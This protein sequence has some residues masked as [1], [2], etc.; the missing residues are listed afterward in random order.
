MTDTARKTRQLDFP[1]VAEAAQRALRVLAP[2][3]RGAR[4]EKGPSNEATDEAL[5]T[6]LEML[7][8]SADEHGFGSSDLIDIA[9]L[10]SIWWRTWPEHADA[11]VHFLETWPPTEKAVCV[12]EL[13]GLGTVSGMIRL[14][15]TL[16]V[17]GAGRSSGCG[18]TCRPPFGALIPLLCAAHRV[19]SAIKLRP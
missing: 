7:S 6:E 5:W 4:A 8:S 2:D 11:M 1:A 14:L 17:S 12:D 19:T 9:L 3:D 10:C 16:E 15:S 13:I 18:S